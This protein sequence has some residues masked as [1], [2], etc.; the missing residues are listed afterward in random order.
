VGFDI[1]TLKDFE[2]P[3]FI[4]EHC[5]GLLFTE[6]VEWD[7]TVCPVCG[8]PYLGDKAMVDYLSGTSHRVDR[9]EVMERCRRLVG[10]IDRLGAN[11]YSWPPIRVL[12]SLLSQSRQFV[13]ITTRGVD[14]QMMGMLKLL[15]ERVAVRL[16]VTSPSANV[17]Q[18]IRDFGSERPHKMEIR[19]PN[20]EWAD[21]HQKVVVID[22]LIAI[23]GSANLSTNAWR[24]AAD[25]RET[26]HLHTDVAEV[27]QVNNRYFARHW[28]EFGPRTTHIDTSVPF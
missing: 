22:G 14:F 23:T 17:K 12:F 27:A 28:A 5:R 25:D 18:E 6:V 4:C 1:R 9:Q 10:T 7:T 19:V 15:G 2:L 21:P 3:W 20:A 16:L 24:N 11:R 8:T 13:H 26:V